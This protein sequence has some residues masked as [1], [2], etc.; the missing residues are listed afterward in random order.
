MWSI[1]KPSPEAITAFLWRNA[2]AVYSYPDVGRAADFQPEG[3]D[4]DSR[5]EVV[6][7]GEEAFFAAR[8]VFLRWAQFPRPWTEIRPKEAPLRAGQTLAMLAHAYGLWWTNACRIVYVVDEPARFGFAYGTLNDHVE[9]G[10]E[11]F[12][13]EQSADGAVWYDIR[14]FSRPRHW[15]VRLAYPLARRQQ[16]QFVRESLATMR[17]AVAESLANLREHATR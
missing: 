2:D 8:E 5:R 12:L 13:I 16:R 17:A 6:G 7:H 9:Q 15:A 14:S 4:R 11:Q 3:Y 10:E 1:R